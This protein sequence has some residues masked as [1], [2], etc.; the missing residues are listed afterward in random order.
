[1]LQFFFSCLFSV[2][3]L[4]LES[5]LTDYSSQDLVTT[6]YKNEYFVEFLDEL[7]TDVAVYYFKLFTISNKRKHENFNKIFLI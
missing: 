5:F 2:E 3:K 1:M 4:N 7:F 6:H